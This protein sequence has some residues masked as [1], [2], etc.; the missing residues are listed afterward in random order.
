VSATTIR[1]EKLDFWLEHEQ[2]VLFVGK[3]GVGKTAMIKQCF[4]RHDLVLGETFLY[5]SASTLDPWVDL[6]GVPKERITDKVPEAFSIIK[7]M[8]NIDV[9]LAYE[10][11]EKNWH[12]GEEACKKV[13][14]HALDRQDGLT[15]LDLVRPKAF[16]QAKVEALF[17]DEFNRS[18]KKVRNAV[19]ECLQFKSINGKAFPNL[20]VVWAAINPDD[21]DEYD[22]EKIDPAQADRFH[23]TVMVPYKPSATWFI[24]RFGDRVAKAAISWWDEL[25][26]EEK[27]KVSPRRLE[28]AL[29]L[30][31]VKGDIRD[32]LPVSSNVTKLGQVLNV[33]PAS[34]KVEEFYKAKDTTAARLFLS[35]ENNY[36][37]AIR[38][39]TDSETLMEFFL[40]L[41]NKEKLSVL[42]SSNDRACR[43]ICARGGQYPHFQAVMK[44]IL[45]ANQNKKL[46]KRI[47]KA[48]TENQVMAT[49]FVGAGASQPA[50]AHYNEKPAS[51]VAWSQQ[52]AQMKR[53]QMDTT[54]QRMKLY[55]QITT[56]IPKVMTPDDAL[57]TLELFD[58]IV[59]RCWTSTVGSVSLK[60]LI[61][62][63][64]H[65]IAQVAQ[66]T[67]KGWVDIVGTH[68]GR[69]RHLLEKVKDAGLANK[70]FTPSGSGS[71][72]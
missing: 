49:S 38:Y 24:Q 23:I 52:V 53:E 42:M 36:N 48:L 32:V 14:G 55:N 12:L 61:N 1:D 37:S 35:N 20:K 41:L 43:F 16:A 11:V 9:A 3:H 67:G 45:N 70:L 6:V 17:F 46:V 64:N 44:D 22:V 8:A 63:V 21:E 10:W 71:G 18:P 13:V 29:N 27:G 69:I 30:W 5:F 33:G 59:G 54:Q 56:N 72:S 60:L 57:A 19:M 68:G 65:C 39:I 31:E 4:E 26:D 15:Y 51:T 34:D 28:Y 58:L 40:P 7:E 47:R 62:M 66:G 50:P 25:S 2:N